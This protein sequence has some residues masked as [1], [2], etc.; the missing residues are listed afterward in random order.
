L[1]ALLSFLTMLSF[2]CVFEGAAPVAR[3]MKGN[4]GFPLGGRSLKF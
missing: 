3:T 2:S 4:I 1:T